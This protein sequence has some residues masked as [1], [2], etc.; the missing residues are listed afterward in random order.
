M[1]IPVIIIA[2]NIGTAPLW[3]NFP[4]VNFPFTSQDKCQLYV[5]N[6]RNS[7]T[8]DPQYIEGYSVCINVPP[9]NGEPT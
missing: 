8:K 4:M 6:V 3:V 2:W 7:I 9:K 5:A 1:W